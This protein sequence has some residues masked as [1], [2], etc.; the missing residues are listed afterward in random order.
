VAETIEYEQFDHSAEAGA[1][2]P[3][4]QVDLSRLSEIPME[5]SVEIGRTHM[6]VGETLDLCVGA[7]VTLERLAGETADLL[8][9]GSAIA[10]GEVVVIDEQYGLRITEILDGR[11]DGDEQP[12]SSG[13]GVA[14]HS[15]AV[16]SP[17]TAAA[18][19]ADAPLSDAS[20]A[21]GPSGGPPPADAPLADAPT[22]DAPLSDFPP[23]EEPPADAPPSAVLPEE[24]GP[25][26]GAPPADAPLADA[27]LGDEAVVDAEVVDEPLAD[28][29]PAPAGEAEVPPA[30]DA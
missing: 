6:T 9:N 12:V 28:A 8:V 21:D 26:G 27:P 7:V 23:G 14:S 17:P 3:A 2:D 15:P 25:R 29:P 11:A 4:A 22:A 18:P 1:G 16:A 19:L 13:A 10:R 24:Y 30:E 5:L 20:Q